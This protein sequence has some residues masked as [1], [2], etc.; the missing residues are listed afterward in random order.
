[1]QYLPRLA[2]GLFVAM[3]P[4][5]LVT[6]SVRWV[7][8][9]PW[10][11]S[12]GFD[13]YDIPSSWMGIERSELLSAGAQ[14]RDYFNNDA[15]WLDVR[16]AVRSVQRS[17]YNRREVLHMRD[18]KALVQKTYLAQIAAAVYLVAFAA[19]GLYVARR[20]FLGPLARYAALGGGLTIGLVVLVGLVALVGF[21]R[22]FLAFHLLS[23]S[24]DLWQLDPRTD[25]L[26]AMFPQAFFFDAAMLIALSTIGGAALLSAPFVY[27]RW[28]P[29]RSWKRTAPVAPAG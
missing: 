16:V 28:R 1:M 5:F 9:A 29:A 8:N 13:K 11:Y 25:Y 7:I 12:Y 14:I 10:V 24:N 17:I 27:L 15:G 22:V 21:D 2:I 3:V 4:V 18:V 26:I 19:V 6:S 20:R 23:F